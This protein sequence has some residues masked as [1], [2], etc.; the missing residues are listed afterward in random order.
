MNKLYHLIACIIVSVTMQAQQ[1]LI[2]LVQ[3]AGGYVSPVDVKHCGDER[4]FVVEQPGYIRVLQKDGTKQATPFLNISAKTLSTGSEQGLL[5][6]A[7]SP[8]YKQDGFFYVNYTTGTGSGSTRI[9]RFSRMANDSSQADANSEVVLITFAQP[10]TNHNGGNLMFGPDGYL[11]ISLGDGGSGNDPDKNGQNKNTLMG[12]MLRIDVANQ[13][14]YAIPASN[15]FVGQ[16]NVK[17]EIWA[18]GLRNAWRCSFD[19][20]TGDL[21]LADVGQDAFEEINFQA[22]SSTGGENYGWLCREGLSSTPPP[23]NLSG[24]GSTGFVDPIHTLSH[25]SGRGCSVTGGYVY[26]GA[27]HSALFGRY[28]FTDY[29]NGIFWSIRQTGS[30][31]FSIDSLRDLSNYR[32]SSFGEDNNGELYVCFRASAMASTSIIYRLTDTSTC[33]PVAFVSLKD[34]FESCAPISLTALKGENLNYQ[35][36]NANDSI[37]GANTNTF[38][39]YQ[40]GAYRVRVR[41]QAAGCQTFSKWI[42]VTIND[43]TALVANNQPLTFCNTD[44]AQNISSH[45]SPQGGIFSGNGISGNTFHPAMAN[46]G[47][48]AIQYDYT[49]SFGCKSE[50]QF[51]IQVAGATALIK[52]IPITSYCVTDSAFSLNGFITP[53]GGQYHGIDVSANKFTPST[54]GTSKVFYTY[55]NTFNCISIDSFDINVIEC[56]PNNISE[57]NDDAFSIY[58]NPSNGVFYVKTAVA[59]SIIITVSDILGSIYFHKTI[60]NNIHANSIEIHLPEAVTGM[61]FI[62]LKTAEKTL[63]SKILMKR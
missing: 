1:P 24:C 16:A 10:Y 55:A 56:N 30:N 32:Y 57:K 9:S 53:A 36:F 61:Y 17:E 52:N 41:K 6:L 39:V 50:L 23:A 49:N 46:P 21:W 12:K 22:A 5:G 26:R 29:C 14:T 54:Q 35:W 20:I 3:V 34:S 58:P 4:L 15:P 8:N 48:N 11:Y 44:N 31:S 62:Q 37:A 25:S 27:Q 63:C 19:K 38:S 28:I 13:A 18:Y 7:F 60:A 43:T 47:S 51:S 33:N 59:E 2:Q 40:S 42:Y 45:V